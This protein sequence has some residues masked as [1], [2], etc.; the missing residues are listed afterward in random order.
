MPQLTKHLI[1]FVIFSNNSSNI[2]LCQFVE[3]VK[4][5]SVDKSEEVSIPDLLELQLMSVF[6]APLVLFAWVVP[7]WGR[8]PRCLLL[9]WKEQKFPALALVLQFQD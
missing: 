4:T 8:R 5:S 6:C 3:D 9:Q 7:V 2:D 1:P